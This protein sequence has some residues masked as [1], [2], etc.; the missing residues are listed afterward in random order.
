MVEGDRALPARQALYIPEN[1][2][3]CECFDE[4]P[5]HAG[6]FGGMAVGGRPGTKAALGMIRIDSVPT[7][8]LLTVP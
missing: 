2:G 5:I 6:K 7:R 3:G 1:S 8:P 4:D